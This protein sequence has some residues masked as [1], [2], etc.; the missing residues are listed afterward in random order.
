MSVLDF[1]PFQL[2]LQ[3]VGTALPFL[4]LV[5]QLLAL[6]LQ[7]PHVVAQTTVLR[8]QQLRQRDRPEANGNMYM[9]MYSRKSVAALKVRLNDVNSLVGRRRI[10]SCIV[11]ILRP[12]LRLVPAD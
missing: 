7:P 4:L 10:A 12:R 6:L 11:H 2:L 9:Y 3:F 1:H 8:L 5:C